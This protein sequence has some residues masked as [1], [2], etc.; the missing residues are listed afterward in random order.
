MLLARLIGQKHD[1]EIV[2]SAFGNDVWYPIRHMGIKFRKVEGELFLPQY[3]SLMARLIDKLKGDVIVAVKPRPTSYGVALLHRELTGRP[4]VLDIDDDEMAFYDGESWKDWDRKTLLRRPNSPLYI[5]MLDALIPQAN[6]ITVA[7]RYL[8]RQYGGHYLTHVKDSEE[9]DP[10]K[11]DG[12]AERQKRK[13]PTSE[14]LIVF[15]GTPRAHKGLELLIE[16]LHKLERDDVKLLIAGFSNDHENKYE[17]HLRMEGGE[18]LYV[19]KQVRFADLPAILAMADVVVLPQLESPEARA[20]MPSKLFDAMAL[21]IPIVATNISD[22]PEA[23]S[24]DCGVVVPPNDSHALS[25]AIAKVL[26]DEKLAQ[27]LRRNARQRLISRYSFASSQE[28]IET[29]LKAATG[30]RK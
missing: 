1:V 30:G 18:L 6:A 16:A 26:D 2:G 5:K 23:L 24:D 21:G 27:S 7:S 9:L 10:S 28:T 14:K 29:V 8:Q 20:Q 17:K 11:F 4:V 13:I 3:T 22:I 25:Q 19:L 15:A 12:E